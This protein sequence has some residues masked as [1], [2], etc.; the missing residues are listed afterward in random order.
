M[1][2]KYRLSLSKTYTKG[3]DWILEYHKKALKQV[4]FKAFKLVIN[5][6]SEVLIE[7][8]EVSKYESASRRFKRFLAHEIV[9]RLK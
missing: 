3:I 5:S 7:D 6:P 1:I 9:K 4:N 8:P 2:Y